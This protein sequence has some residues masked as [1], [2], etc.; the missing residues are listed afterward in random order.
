M[1]RIWGIPRLVRTAPNGDLF[2]A[3]SEADNILLFRGVSSDGKARQ[4]EEFATGLSQPF[5]IAFFPP[6][7]NPKWIYV[8]DTTP[9]C[10]SRTRTAS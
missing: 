4:T 7:P 9:W 2:L 1:R 6:G 8:G 5:G 10:D 3:D